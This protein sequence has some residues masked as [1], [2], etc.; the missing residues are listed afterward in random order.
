VIVTESDTYR[1]AIT[2]D[3]IGADCFHCGAAIA[4]YPLGLWQGYG[5]TIFLHVDCMSRLGL[6]FQ[7]DATS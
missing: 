5:A 1:E 6:R 3:P 4:E 2:G 7:V